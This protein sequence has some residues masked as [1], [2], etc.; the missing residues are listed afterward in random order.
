MEIDVSSLDKRSGKVL[1]KKVTVENGT[2]SLELKLEY[3]D[4]KYCQKKF[5]KWL[6]AGHS[7]EKHALAEEGEDKIVQD[8]LSTPE[9]MWEDGFSRRVLFVTMKHCNDLAVKDVFVE[10]SKR[11]WTISSEMDHI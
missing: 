6:L 8:V 2:G 11:E 1:S 5:P 3:N 10:V 9:E 4:F 7:S